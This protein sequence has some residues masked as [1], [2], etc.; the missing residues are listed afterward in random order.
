MVYQRKN[1]I[2]VIQW[3]FGQLKE[4]K[5]NSQ[6]GTQ[7]LQQPIIYTVRRSFLTDIVRL[8][9]HTLTRNISLES[10]SKVILFWF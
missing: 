9:M 7:H 6:I 10:T 1:F 3:I 2:G 5:N 8:E 4:K